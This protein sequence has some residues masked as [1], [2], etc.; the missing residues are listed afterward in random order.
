ML[1]YV[2]DSTKQQLFQVNHIVIIIIMIMIMIITIMDIIEILH[3]RHH[4]FPQD[5]LASAVKRSRL[6]DDGEELP[7][8]IKM[9]M[10]IIAKTKLTMMIMIMIMRTMITMTMI[11]MMMTMLMTLI[12]MT[13]IIMTLDMTI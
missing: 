1:S 3:L 9:R 10:V 5:S 2:L 11:I 8:M 7:F 12:M 4:L 6:G 13:M